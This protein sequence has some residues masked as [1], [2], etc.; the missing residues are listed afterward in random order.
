MEEV[1]LSQVAQVA[2]FLSYTP[3]P[4]FHYNIVGVFC[5]E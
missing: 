4:L 3:L 2:D 5:N 1:V